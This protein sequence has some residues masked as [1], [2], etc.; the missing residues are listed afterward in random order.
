[1]VRAVVFTAHSSVSSTVPLR[2][3]EAM[4]SC[5]K[6]ALAFWLPDA[7]FSLAITR[8]WLDSSSCFGNISTFHL[9][10]PLRSFAPHWYYG[11]IPVILYRLHRSG[12]CK[13]DHNR[14]KLH[15]FL[16]SH[17]IFCPH[18]TSRSISQ[19][20][21]WCKT[22][23]SFSATNAALPPYWAASGFDPTYLHPL[24]LTKL[25]SANM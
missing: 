3:Q 22:R 12:H 8:R 17:G 24:P 23:F 1:M 7:A 10:Q 9:G 14:L 18:S 4:S 21:A 5:R 11:S 16:I 19:L 25:I 6:W 2:C 15:I 13:T 20:A